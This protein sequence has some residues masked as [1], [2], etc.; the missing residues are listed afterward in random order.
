[1]KKTTS[2]LLLG[3][4]FYN[5]YPYS[6]NPSTSIMYTSY[7]QY[8]DK[9]YNAKNYSNEVLFLHEV[10]SNYHC[11]K[12]LDL[13][14]GTG[15]HISKL[16]KYGYLCTGIDLNTEMLGRAKNKIQGKVFQ[17]DMRNFNLKDEFDAIIC[18]FAVFNHNLC[19]NDALQTLE[20]IKK[21]LKPNGILILD[22]YNPQ[23]SG[24]KTETFN[25]VTRI[26]NWNLDIENKICNSI[27]RF[28]EGN[29][30]CESNFPLKL[31]SIPDM[32]YILEKAG[33]K[34]YFFY[35][36]YT[37]AEG[38]PDSKNLIIVA[39]VTS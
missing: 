5:S 17:A 26:M 16:E 29:H 38:K 9:F 28:V 10:L 6:D 8:Y 20:Q 37:L 30:V 13:G 31:Y 32:Q 23:S 34:K 18:M 36:N 24:E 39:Q 11:K 35:D 4:S 27:V 14:C 3:I 19:N 2:I 21:H 1:M 22:L 12:I 15:T 7:A 25:N 33:Y